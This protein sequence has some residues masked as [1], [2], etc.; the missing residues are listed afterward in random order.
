V[1]NDC[2]G[3]VVPTKG[4]DP[5]LELGAGPGVEPKV[6]CV[7]A[8]EP[9]VG[10]GAGVEPKGVGTN[11]TEAGAAGVEP[12]G[13]AVLATT[14]DPNVVSGTGTG[15][16]PTLPKW[17]VSDNPADPQGALPPNNRSEA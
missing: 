3:V 10:P 11:G 15:A 7:G 5:K 8:A 14:F 13:P 12:K 2:A 17:L 1:V 16:E 6:A 9:N 4:V